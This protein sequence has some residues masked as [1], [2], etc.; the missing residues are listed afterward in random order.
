MNAPEQEPTQKFESVGTMGY[1]T[2]G[3][4]NYEENKGTEAQAAFVEQ[5]IEN[6][7]GLVDVT[8]KDDGCIDGRKTFLALIKKGANFVKDKIDA[9]TKQRAKVAGGGYITGLAMRLGIAPTRG[10]TAEADLSKLGLDF[11]S[12]GIVCGAHTGPVHGNPDGTGCGANDSIVAILKNANTFRGDVNA[13]DPKERLLAG[14]TAALLAK[15]GLEFKPELFNEIVDTWQDAANDTAYFGGTGKSR[16]DVI[17]ATQEAV[18]TDEEQ[19][20]MT[21]ELEGEHKEAY[22]IINY[23]EGKTFSQAALYEALHKEFP[24]TPVEDLPQAFVVDAWRIVE[25][26]KGAAKG[27]DVEKAIYAGVMY[28]LATATTLTDGTLKVFTNK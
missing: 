12:E 10:E 8:E 17:E 25:L 13:E 21:R 27:D 18:S 2:E 23:V 1:G 11:A 5:F 15:A 9:L 16:L 7:E 26:A 4:I 14:T 3:K 20:A 22:I 24:E 28:Q 6:G 19:P